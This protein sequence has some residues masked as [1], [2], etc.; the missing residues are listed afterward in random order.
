M[1]N[2][3]GALNLIT[4]RY[5]LKDIDVR[6]AR[7]SFKVGEVEFPAGSFII[8]GNSDRVRKE[9]AALGLSAT[10][11]AEA[12]K[13]QT[14]E[15]ELPRLA[16]YTTWSNTE[17]VGWVRLAF[18]RWEIPYD[19]IHKDHARQGN[20]RSKYDVIVMPHQ[21][22]NGRSLVHEQPKLSKPLPYKK[23]DTFK[24]LGFYAET[25]DVRGGMGLEGAA[26]FARFVEERRRAA[27]HGRLELLPDRVWA[28]PIRR[29]AD[30]FGHVVRARAL[31]ADRYPAAV[32]S[33]AL[34]LSRAEDAAD[35]VGGRAAAASD[36]SRRTTEADRATGACP[37]DRKPRM[38]SCASKAAT[39]AC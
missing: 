28:D 33:G 3:N 21:G 29:C 20:L 14:V 37:R 5:R 4:L 19:L 9:V 27:D 39:P 8:S 10:A 17:K 15:L 12:P 34:R 35:A 1:I 23:N 25:D 16:V 31:R 7:S 13:V 26:E 24:T 6:A 32:A 22:T 36:R 30:P 11:V 38:S 2:H 18:D